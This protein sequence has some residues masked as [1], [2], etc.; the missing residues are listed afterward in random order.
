MAI[1]FLRDALRQA[2]APEWRLLAVILLVLATATNAVILSE[3]GEPGEPPSPIFLLAAVIRLAGLLLLTVA[4]LRRATD[5][6]RAPFMPDGAFWLMVLLTLLGFAVSAGVRALLPDGQDNLVNLVAGNALAAL[7]TSPLAVWTVALAT[8]KPLAI[9]PRPRLREFSLWLPFLVIWQLLI[10]VPLSALHAYIDVGLVEGTI[11]R[12]A[13]LEIADGALS[14]LIVLIGL[15]LSVTAY[16][17][18][19]NR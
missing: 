1:G 10:V 12:S 7:I 3:I 14:M 18:V 8:E 6:R 9:D 16:R 15:A 11:A 17:R 2:I 13:A 19:A 5:S 4:L